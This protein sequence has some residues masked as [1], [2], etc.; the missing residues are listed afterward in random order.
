MSLFGT[1]KYVAMSFADLTALC[2]KHNGKTRLSRNNEGA[3]SVS[4]VLANGD[5]G[6][7]RRIACP[8]VTEDI[9]PRGY[10]VWYSQA[11]I[12]VADAGWDGPRAWKAT[13]AAS[14]TAPRAL[15]PDESA[16]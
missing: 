10:E 1:R 13:K 16:E 9:L 4:H 7:G 12:G 11:E 2:A 3:L 15:T 8:E 14:G 6:P 5:M